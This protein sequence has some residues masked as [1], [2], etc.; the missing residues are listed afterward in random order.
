MQNVTAVVF[1]RAGRGVAQTTSTVCDKAVEEEEKGGPEGRVKAV[2]RF[3]IAPQQGEGDCRTS[4]REASM[5]VKC[6][7]PISQGCTGPRNEQEE[8]M[9]TV[10]IA[11]HCGYEK[12]V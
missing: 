9:M 5:D 6:L 8:Q 1:V 3:T 12:Q 2:R 11:S 4:I 10:T 7:R